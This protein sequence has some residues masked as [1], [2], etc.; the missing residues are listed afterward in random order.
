MDD[1]KA[2][3]RYEMYED[4]TY[5]LETNGHASMIITGIFFLL[6]DF[7]TQCVEDGIIEKKNLSAL[8]DICEKRLND[9]LNGKH[10]TD[11]IK[12]E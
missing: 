12:E 3:L 4:K 1:K 8:F 11:W 9:C 7:L 10:P 2:I 5:A 6:I